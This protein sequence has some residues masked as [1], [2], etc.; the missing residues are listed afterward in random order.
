MIDK[1]YEIGV[2]KEQN[3]CCKS[4]KA[5][6]RARLF[7]QIQKKMFVQCK[8][9]NFTGQNIISL[10]CNYIVFI[11]VGFFDENSY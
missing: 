11:Q 2:F 4:T 10:Q 5:E 8:V 6:R 9:M 7:V 1:K 3:V